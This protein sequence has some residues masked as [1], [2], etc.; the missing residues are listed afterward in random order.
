[1]VDDDDENA[2]F[3]LDKYNILTP[4]ELVHSSE[5]KQERER[6]CGTAGRGECLMGYLD[7]PTP[8]AIIIVARLYS[9]LRV[10]WRDG[11]LHRKCPCTS[12]VGCCGAV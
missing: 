7:S 3:H 8:L 2:T 12:R 6:G 4:K 9:C 1:M 10:V 11:F 5:L